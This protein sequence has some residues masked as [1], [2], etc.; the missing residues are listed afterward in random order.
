[1]S[2]DECIHL[3]RTQCQYISLASMEPPSLIMSHQNAKICSIKN[4]VTV[5]L[6]IVIHICMDVIPPF[7]I[8]TMVGCKVIFFWLS[9]LQMTWK[10][11]TTITIVWKVIVYERWQLQVLVHEWEIKVKTLT[12]ASPSTV[13]RPHMPLLPHT[14]LPYNSMWHVIHNNIK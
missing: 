10:V 7:Y 9:N 12:L 2:L 14:K 3:M 6:I 11:T 13:K 1:M 8:N 5:W 4:W